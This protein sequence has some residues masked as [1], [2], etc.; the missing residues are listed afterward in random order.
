MKS[1]TTKEFRKRLKQLPRP[2]YK[3]AIRAYA[4]WRKD[5]YHRSLHFERVSQ[6]EPLYSVHIGIKYRALGAVEN[7]QIYWIW[8]GSHAEYDEL[9]KRMR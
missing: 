4:L 5:P 8:I 6:S 1:R 3:N 2:V 9:L 7:G